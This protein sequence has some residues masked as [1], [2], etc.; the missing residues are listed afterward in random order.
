MKK[1]IGI[2][3]EMYDWFVN[4]FPDEEDVEKL[5]QIAYQ[6]GYHDALQRQ[7]ES[8]DNKNGC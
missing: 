2:P 8:E 4:G 5:W 3:D 7:E 6:K 1:L